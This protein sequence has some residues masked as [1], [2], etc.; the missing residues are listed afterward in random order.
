MFSKEE[1]TWQCWA[2]RHADADLLQKLLLIIPVLNLLRE[3]GVE[4]CK[5]RIQSFW[6]K[7]LAVMNG[8]KRVTN[9]LTKTDHR[10]WEKGN[11]VCPSD[12]W[13]TSCFFSKSY[14]SSIHLLPGTLRIAWHQWYVLELV[15]TPTDVPQVDGSCKEDLRRPRAIVLL[16]F[17]SFIVESYSLF[18][19]FHGYWGT[20]VAFYHSL[21]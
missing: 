16:I 20:L 11:S 19:P 21:G 9:E 12:V 14:K 15:Q 18:S 1:K 3:I 5:F 13:N 7:Q 2:T 8:S 10:M 4:N 17:L 6:V